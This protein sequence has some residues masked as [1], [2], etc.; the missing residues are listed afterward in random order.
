ME[1]FDALVIGAGPAGSSTAIHLARGGARVLLVDRSPFPRSKPCGGGL[2]AR[3]VR[4]SPVDPAPVVEHLIDRLE[5]SHPSSRPFVRGGGPTLVFATQ[6]RRLDAFLAATAVSAGVVFR[7]GARV[8]LIDPAGRPVV[9]V[10]GQP[11]R[12]EAVVGADGANGITAR[13]CGLSRPST[14]GVAYEGTVPFGRQESRFRGTAVIELGTVG[15]GYAW[16]LPKGDHLNVGIGGWQREGG[17]LRRRLAEFCARHGVDPTLLAEVRGHRL[18]LRAV[19]CRLGGGRALLVGDAAG[20][21]DPLSA[22]GMYE[23][24]V[25]ARLAAA[26][27]LAMLAGRS[28]D[29]DRFTRDVVTRLG[30]LAAASWDARVALDRFPRATL[31]VLRLPVTWT[32]AERVLTGDLDDPAQTSLIGRVALRAVGALGRLA[33][34]PGHQYRQEAHENS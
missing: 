2:T 4:Q 30:P 25:S 31:G 22:D 5:F 28:P 34:G 24:F 32:I 10:N 27:I 8:D 26:A 17:A 15:G 11:I 20:L 3:A 16:I 18:P 13:A 6:R 12:C 33:G 19:G 21:V 29:L 14:Y 7:D 9:R 23:A 1:E